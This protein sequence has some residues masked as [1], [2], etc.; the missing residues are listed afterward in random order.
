MALIGYARI[1]TNDQNAQLQL[2]A[3][4]G[5]GCEKIFTDVA[6][7]KTTAGRPQLAACLAYL[8]P[9]DTLIVW[10]L[11]RFARSLIDLV[12]QVDELHAEGKGIRVLTGALASVDPNTSDGRMMMQIIGAMAEFERSLI[13][14]RT[15]AGLAAAK[16]QGKAGGRKRVLTDDQVRLAAE[17][18][19]GGSGK[20]LAEIAQLLGSNKATV[21]RAIQRITPPEPT[22]PAAA[23]SSEPPAAATRPADPE[24]S[25]A[26]ASAVSGALKDKGFMPRNPERN[27]SNSGYR[28]TRSADGSIRVS[29]HGGKDTD[30]LSEAELSAVRAG[31]HE[32]YADT[33]AAA[34]YPLGESGTG[35]PV[36]VWGKGKRNN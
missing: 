17:L 27:N 35:A 30:H 34:G 18:H 3:L 10:K 16:A 12:T 8:R 1:S 20:S 31:Q 4:S 19:A 36:V 21:Y 28:A 24:H 32:S 11:D 22:T 15:R 9:G 29:W 25:P 14:E 23:K 13:V 7:G 33:L 5:A 6:S 26:S 2:D